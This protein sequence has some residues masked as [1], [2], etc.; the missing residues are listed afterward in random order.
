MTSKELDELAAQ[1]NCNENDARFIADAR[2]VIPEI[3]ARVRELEQQVLVLS[4][5]VA[6]LET[7]GAIKQMCIQELRQQVA[8]LQR[9]R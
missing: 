6:E 1:L 7:K 3:I 5:Q 9:G 4:R 2:E 8:E